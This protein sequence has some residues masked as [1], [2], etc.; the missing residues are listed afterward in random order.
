MREKRLILTLLLFLTFL[1]NTS[2]AAEQKHVY[3]LEDIHGNPET[4]KNHLTTLLSLSKNNGLT[5]VAT[6]GSSG[7][8]STAPIE[9]SFQTTSERLATIQTLFEKS[10]IN[11]AHMLKSISRTHFTVVGVENKSVYLKHLELKEKIKKQLPNVLDKL[12]TLS[13]QPTES[14]LSFCKLEATP[15]IAR[16]YLKTTSF[17]EDS[18]LIKEHL[19]DVRKFYNIAFERD[20]ILSE[21]IID[22]IELEGVSQAAL[23]VGGFHTEGIKQVLQERQ[24]AVTVISP[25]KLSRQTL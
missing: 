24:I 13:W 25:D 19:E 8:I 23:V 11:A 10:Q 6:E 1:V 12:T 14:F 18:S 9:Y 7:Y 22:R 3:L 4:Q 20:F 2:E 16:K 15:E 21:N 5:L 17:L